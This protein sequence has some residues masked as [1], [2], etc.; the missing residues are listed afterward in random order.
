NREWQDAATVDF[1]V[2]DAGGARHPATL[3]VMNDDQNLF[4]AVRVTKFDVGKWRLAIDFDNDGDGKL[5]TGD[6]R[7]VVAPAFEGFADETWRIGTPLCAPGP[8]PSPCAID[9]RELGG[10]RA[11]E[12]R[13]GADR[14]DAIY[15]IRRP[16]ASGD[17]RNDGSLVPNSIAGLSVTCSGSAGC[18]R[19]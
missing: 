3:Y 19:H 10:T 11:G 12:A 1:H 16:L 17:E 4:L 18:A 6:D 9:D 2:L 8:V 5:E 7:L 15:E 13:T 14:G